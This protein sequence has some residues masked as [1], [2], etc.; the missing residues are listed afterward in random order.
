MVE[1]IN[2]WLSGRLSGRLI[3]ILFDFYTFL[4]KILGHRGPL[5]PGPLGPRAHGPPVA[6]YVHWRHSWGWIP[7]QILRIPE[8]I[9]RFLWKSKNTVAQFWAGCSKGWPEI[10]ILDPIREGNGNPKTPTFG[11]DGGSG[12]DGDGGGDDDDGG[13]ISQ[14]LPPPPHHAQGWNIPF[15]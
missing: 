5:G 1:K 7:E 13:R 15:G 12:G 14:H 8:Q 9:R 3:Y 10:S 4:V 11:G 2:L 6:M